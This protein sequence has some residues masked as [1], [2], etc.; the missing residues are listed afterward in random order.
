M[1]IFHCALEQRDLYFGI[2]KWMRRASGFTDLAAW[3]R[4]CP[5]WIG[6]T[7]QFQ[8]LIGMAKLLFDLCW[9]SRPGNVLKRR[10]DADARQRPRTTD[11]TKLN[12]LG[13]V[14]VITPGQSPPLKLKV[15]RN[16]GMCRRVMVAEGCCRSAGLLHVKGLIALLVT[17]VDQIRLCC[18]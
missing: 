4:A 8:L 2:G 16:G 12:T 14:Q 18:L 1:V 9:I 5:T 15:L 13:L 6:L 3:L 11:S 17:S 7:R 10:F